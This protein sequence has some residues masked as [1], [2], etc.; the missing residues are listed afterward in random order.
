MSN[1]KLEKIEKQVSATKRDIR[2]N[3]YQLIFSK[4]GTFIILAIF[5]AMLISAETTN[6]SIFIG[7]I[8]L[9]IVVKLALDYRTLFSKRASLKESLDDLI[10]KQKAQSSST[11]SG[12]S[13]TAQVP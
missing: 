6:G 7:A 2:D 3:T 8:V 10:K 4:F 5:S 13:N 11:T 9:A 12:S 1:D